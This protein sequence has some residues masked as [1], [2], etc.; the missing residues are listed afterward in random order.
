MEGD[1]NNRQKNSGGNR[2][3]FQHRRQ[4]S[5]N[6]KRFDRRDGGEN[7]E[8]RQHRDNKRPQRPPQQVIK[9]ETTAEEIAAETKSIEAEILMEIEELRSLKVKFGS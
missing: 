4:R 5:Q 2:N 7:R 6:D 1:N 9:H 8:N 3:R